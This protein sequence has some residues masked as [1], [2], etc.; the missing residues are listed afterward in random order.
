MSSEK[1]AV[2]KVEHEDGLIEYHVI[3][4]EGWDDCESL[5]RFIVKQFGAAVDSQA[6][7]ICSR[8]WKLRI[9]EVQIHLKHHDDIGNFFSVSPRTD[10]SNALLERVANELNFRLSAEP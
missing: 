5:A 10:E 1:T 7:G 4:A 2:K 9:G 8:E 3:A 6:D